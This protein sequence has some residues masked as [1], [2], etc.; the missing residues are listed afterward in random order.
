[1][2]SLKEDLG[3]GVISLPRYA[4]RLMTLLEQETNSMMIDHFQQTLKTV[5]YLSRLVKPENDK[6]RKTLDDLAQH[7]EDLSWQQ[8]DLT[9]D[10]TSQSWFD[11]WT[12]V[13][14]TKEALTHIAN[15]LDGKKAFNNFTLQQYQRWQMIKTLNGFNWPDAE[16]RIA[17]ELKKDGSEEG[18]QYAIAAKA[19]RPSLENKRY[20][21]NE[22]LNPDKLRSPSVLDAISDDLFPVNQIKQSRFLAQEIFSFIPQ[23]AQKDHGVQEQFGK[24]LVNECSAEGIRH[25]DQTIEKYHDFSSIILNALKDNRQQ[26]E[27]CIS[28]SENILH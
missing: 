16:Q 1:M 9:V 15:I 26:T 10:D 19:I 20:W 4:E 3:E 12:S 7:I 11:I 2:Q 18:Q 21:I 8:T 6:A 28:M 17:R 25:L 13:A 22:L 23:V 27:R 14:H 5:F 24:L